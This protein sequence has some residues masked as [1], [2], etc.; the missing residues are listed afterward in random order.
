[1][2]LRKLEISSLQMSVSNLEERIR[3]LQIEAQRETDQGLKKSLQEGR[4]KLEQALK[5]S[6][7]NEQRLLK[8]EHDIEQ[9][10]K[11]LNDMENLLKVR[12][13][14]IGMMKTK[15]DELSQEN[16]SLNQ[17]AEQVRALLI[18]VISVPK[19]SIALHRQ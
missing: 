2:S 18:Q 3:A 15:K 9:K 12:D 6:L 17:Y 4:L 16:E 7:E 19:R 10:T 5:R 13:G 1:M 14:L 11:Q 8:F